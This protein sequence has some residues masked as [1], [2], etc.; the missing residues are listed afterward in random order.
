MAKYL[1]CKKKPDVFQSHE[2]KRKMFINMKKLTVLSST[3]R[4]RVTLAHSY[5]D[6]L[7][8]IVEHSTKL[9]WF[10][11]LISIHWFN[12]EHQA[13]AFAQ[14]IVQECDTNSKSTCKKGKE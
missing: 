7:T 4:C 12:D 3:H 11:K 9:M 2:S 10:K 5:T 8:W 13:L 6:P 14:N 1:F